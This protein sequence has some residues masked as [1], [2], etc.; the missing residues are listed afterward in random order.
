MILV[1]SFVISRQHY[2]L[3]GVS[4]SSVSLPTFYRI[5]KK[6]STEGF[7][8]VPYVVAL[9][10]AMLWIY[11]ALLKSDATLLMSINSVGCVI[12]TIYI[13]LY[14]AYAPKK[15]RI[16]TLKL[17]LL[18]IFAGFFLILLLTQFLAKGPARLR[19]LGWICLVLSVSVFAAPLSIMTQVVR[20]KSVEFMPFWLSF[21]LAL[22]AVMWFLYGL[23]QKDFFITLPNI[24]GFVFGV[25]QMVLYEIY[26]NHK[27]PEAEQK[28]PTIVKPGCAKTPE[29]H[30]VC[31]LPKSD[32]IEE[33]KDED[34]HE[35]QTELY[36]KKVVVFAEE[37][38]MF[39][40]QWTLAF[41]L[42]AAC[43][44]PLSFLIFS[45]SL[46]LLGLVGNIISFMVYL[47]PVPTFYQ[48]YIK[49]SA[50]GFQSIPYIVSL[51]S[52]M[53]WIY[54]ALLKHNAML[55][56]TINSV[57]CF[58][59]SIYVCFYLF[60]APKKSR[61]QTVKLLLSLNGGGFGLIVVLTQFLAKQ[62]TCFKIVGWICL[63]FSLSVFVAPLGVV[64]QVIRT[65]SVEYMPILLSFFLTLSAVIWFFYGLLLNDYN[66]AIPNVLGFIFGVLQMVLY[67]MYKNAKK[68]IEHK[69]PEF[70]NQVIMLDD[71]KLP[72]LK[73][74]II[75]VVQLSTMVCAEMIPASTKL[76]EHVHDMV[77]VQSLPKK[78]M[79]AVK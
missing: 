45:F 55:L 73:E 19:V 70:H 54:Y 1:P 34:V 60:Y 59:E 4:S 42:L 64:R 32:E 15:A 76:H 13:A 56:I 66:V 21:F 50:E 5:C 3:L 40:E 68:A 22:S 39:S 41:G 8:S 63:V 2:L 43:N 14:V 75:D 62:D 26:K 71:H 57:G 38:T 67:A 52:A 37:I 24:L 27:G 28:L 31:S 20:T 12:E 10:T 51:F 65:K 69:L 33:A 18:L 44:R 74:Q 25:I 46:L 23:L 53:L 79:E 16:L 78:T 30:P 36:E 47:A 49:K 6:K 7:Q 11:Y 61:I 35:D 72:E 29:V 17:V 77:E 9:F 48:V 58:I